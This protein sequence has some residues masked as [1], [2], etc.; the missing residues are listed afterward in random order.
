MEVD[1][2]IILCPVLQRLRGGHLHHQLCRSVPVCGRQLQG[3]HHRGGEPQAAAEDPS[4]EIWEPL[5]TLK[6]IYIIM[7][8]TLKLR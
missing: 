7:T 6:V 4:G 2:S 1:L 3:Q 8:A 5:L